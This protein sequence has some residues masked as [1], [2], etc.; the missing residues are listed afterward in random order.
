[1][2]P[3]IEEQ[4]KK[5]KELHHFSLPLGTDVEDCLCIDTH[6]SKWI[7]KE[8]A[9][10]Y[11]ERVIEECAEIAKVEEL[12]NNPQ[13]NMFDDSCEEEEFLIEVD[14]QFY[15]EID[16]LCTGFTQYRINAQSILKLK[17]EL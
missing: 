8:F 3:T 1:M 13:F 16:D 5:L 7:A 4:D 6:D 15:W 10:W 2:L 17:E 12:S 14:D 9:K 11:A